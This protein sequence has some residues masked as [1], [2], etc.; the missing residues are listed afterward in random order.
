MSIVPAPRVLS[1]SATLALFLFVLVCFL[2]LAYRTEVND[3]K[4]QQATYQI[5]LNQWQS[6]MGGVRIIRGFNEQQQK[7][8]DV[9]RSQK[10]DTNLAERRIRI[11]EEGQ[12]DLVSDCGP[13]PVP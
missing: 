11:Y 6:C 5:R 12:V 7:L 8:A 2:L 13:Q 9:E 10:I 4:I 3:R 1:R